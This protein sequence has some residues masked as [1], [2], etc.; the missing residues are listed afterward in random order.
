MAEREMRRCFFAIILTC[1]IK[2][3]HHL[4]D[5]D[6]RQSQKSM[7]EAVSPGTKPKASVII[8]VYKDTEALAGILHALD[9]QTE[10]DFEIIVTED[11]ESEEMAGFLAEYKK[12]PNFHH[13]TQP[14]IGWRKPVAENRAIASAR[15]EYLMFLDGDCIPDK[16][17]VAQHLANA[18]PGR[19]LTG[20][21]VYLGPFFSK[22]LRKWPQLVPVIEN[23]LIFLLLLIPLHLDKVRSYE[24]GLSSRFMQWLRGK[25]PVGIIGCNFSCYKKDMLAINGYNEDMTGVG[26]ED[27]DLQWRFEGLGMATKSVKFLIPVY[28]L[29]HVHERTDY[30]QNVAIMN[31]A[32]KHNAFVCKNGIVKR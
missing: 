3:P 22:L 30:E 11:C 2:Q 23:R 6:Y 20:R 1:H 15:S 8:S 25:K 5:K 16:D 4:I 29:Y 14:D 21:R 31:E 24:V 17:F 18:E 12:R 10:K 32:R 28:H 19:F 13:L 26:A 27:S 9:R 7:N